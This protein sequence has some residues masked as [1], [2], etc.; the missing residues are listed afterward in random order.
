MKESIGEWR[1]SGRRCSYQRIPPMCSAID[2]CSVFT[3]IFHSIYQHLQAVMQ[4][5]SHG[6]PCHVHLSYWRLRG[7]FWGGGEISLWLCK[8]SKTIQQIFINMTANDNTKIFCILSLDWNDFTILLFWIQILVPMI[9]N[10]APK[11]YA[12]FS[13]ILLTND[14]IHE[15][16][17]KNPTL[18]IQ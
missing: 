1:L 2:K 18:S 7:F 13:N 8:Y 9:W 17:T 16:Y 14:S 15:A 11:L 5:L 12:V 10:F 4:Q 6:D 3:V